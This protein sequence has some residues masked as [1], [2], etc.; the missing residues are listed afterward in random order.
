SRKDGIMSKPKIEQQ[1][2]LISNVHIP[3]DDAVLEGE[4]RVPYGATSII[5]F[6]NAS[7]TSRHSPRNKYVSKNFLKAGF[8]TLLFDLLMHKE[9]FEDILTSHYRFD[10]DLL[11][12]RLVGVTKW[13]LNQYSTSHLNIGYYGASTG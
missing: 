8:G 13:V 10:I 12:K 2:S 6:A 7:G 11:A 1:V 4:L 5:L 3:L 9:E